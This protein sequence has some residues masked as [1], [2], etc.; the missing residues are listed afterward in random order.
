MHRWF[1]RKTHK[2]SNLCHWHLRHLVSYCSRVIL[3]STA[4]KDYEVYGTCINLIL[5]KCLGLLSVH[6]ISLSAC[7]F[8]SLNYVGDS[9]DFLIPGLAFYLMMKILFIMKI[10]FLQ[11]K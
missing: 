4:L 8:L 9:A 7:L 10:F 6:P 5:I 2:Y 11:L 3:Y 1:E